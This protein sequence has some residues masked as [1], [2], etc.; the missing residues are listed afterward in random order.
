MGLKPT[1]VNFPYLD[2]S[3]YLHALAVIDNTRH[4]Y[5]IIDLVY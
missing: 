3:I 5:I 4:L 2:L 1:R